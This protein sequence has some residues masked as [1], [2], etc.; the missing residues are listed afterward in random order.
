[1]NVHPGAIVLCKVDHCAFRVEKIEKRWDDIALRCVG[2]TGPHKGLPYTI[3]QAE[4]PDYY[5][6]Q[7]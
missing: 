2:L 7:R 1:M 4:F 5:L 3:P 6:E